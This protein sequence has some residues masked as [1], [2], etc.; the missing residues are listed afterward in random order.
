[1]SESGFIGFWDWQDFKRVHFPTPLTQTAPSPVPMNYQYILRTLV[2]GFLFLYT[3]SCSNAQQP[4]GFLTGEYSKLDPNLSI[5]FKFVNLAARDIYNNDFITAACD[6]EEA[7]KHKANPFY[8]DVRNAIIANIK[9]GSP[10][11]NLPLL[12]ILMVYKHLDTA[13]LFLDL[14][15]RIFDRNCLDYIFQLQTNKSSKNNISGKLA[16]G[17][18]HIYVLGQETMN[19]YNTGSGR[20]SFTQDSL[21]K[22]I[23]NVHEQNAVEFIRLCNQ[24][25]FPSE[26]RVG[27]YYDKELPWADVLYNLWT[28]FIHTDQ[29]E[30]L[31]ELLEKARRAGDL[32]PSQYAS[33][34]DLE[35]QNSRGLRKEC[36][37]MNTTVVLSGGKLYRP[38]VY[39]SDSLMRNVNTNRVSIGLDSFHV[40]QKQVACVQLYEK[41]HA[42][43]MKGKKIVRMA[44]YASIEA[45]DIGFVKWAF[46]KDKQDITK[47]ELNV[48]KILD[49]GNCAEKL[50]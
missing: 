18:R 11:K 22:A 5:Y 21:K 39:Y 13:Y 32:H 25:G 31:F 16:A 6:Y 23:A 41:Y 46:D 26:E 7:F 50:Y 2:V 3:H 1:M 37:F 29:K 44:Q 34:L 15:K 33:L 40:V 17:I 35:F 43:E 12:K 30:K 38:F 10:A 28:F 47:Y 8:V 27:V 14:P 48:K 42:D 45:L 19:A 36:N 24:Y 4:R 9:N 20:S 49:E